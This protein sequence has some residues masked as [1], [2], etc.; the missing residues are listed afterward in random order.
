MRFA[1]FLLDPT[2]P[3]EGK[4]R[5]RQ[6]AS[7]S[8]KTAMEERGGSLGIT[9]SRGRTL[10][11]NSHLA[12]EA[13]EFALAAGDGLAFHRA[14]FKAYFEDL[15]D[16]GQV[17][18]VVRVGESAGLDGEALR[19]ALTS[20]TYREQVDDGIRWSRDIGVTGVPTFVFDDTY[21]VVGAQDHDVFVSMMERL[22]RA[23]KGP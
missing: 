23:P 20:G 6:T 14:M 15:E 21:G 17:E 13:A 11:S 9:F 18:T 19:A 3:P 12:L 1:P 2:T 4:P 8:P 7:D 5:Q 22:G 10:T 16:I